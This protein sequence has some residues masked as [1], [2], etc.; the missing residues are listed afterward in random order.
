MDVISSQTID[1]SVREDNIVEDSNTCSCILSGTFDSSDSL[2]KK[3]NLYEKCGNS[4]CFDSGGK[5]IACGGNGSN[6]GGQSDKISIIDS[7]KSFEKN[8]VN[9]K[10]ELITVVLT[11]ILFILVIIWI[12]MQYKK[13][14]N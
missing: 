7:I 2:I 1:N 12:T 4:Q 14:K 10:R 8:I 11:G 6:S 3:L 5:S 13:R 9:D